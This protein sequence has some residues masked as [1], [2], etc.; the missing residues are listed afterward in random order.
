MIHGYEWVNDEEIDAFVRLKY[1][2]S[3]AALGRI[4]DALPLLIATLKEDTGMHWDSELALSTFKE[5]GNLDV[6][7]DLEEVE[8]TSKSA[9]I[10]EQARKTIDAIRARIAKEHEAEVAG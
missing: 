6:L 2:S 10:R 5:Y 1:A 9:E 7:S 4:K 3:L 8:N